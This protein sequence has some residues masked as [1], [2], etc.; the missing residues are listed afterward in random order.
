ME[1]MKNRH[2]NRQ[3]AHT[4]L[5]WIK[6]HGKSRQK[7]LLKITEIPKKKHAETDSKI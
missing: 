1:Q 2:Q 7:S 5:A 4:D 3:N 6:N